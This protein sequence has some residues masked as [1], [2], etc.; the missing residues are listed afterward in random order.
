M[1]GLLL[2]PPHVRCPYASHGS[3]FLYSTRLRSAKQH[4]LDVWTMNIVRLQPVPQ[5]RNRRKPNIRLAFRPIQQE[6]ATYPDG[7]QALE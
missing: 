4:S 7:R 6:S 1:L 3:A 2:L 5:L